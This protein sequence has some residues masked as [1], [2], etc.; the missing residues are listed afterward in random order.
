MTF[1]KGILLLNP[2]YRPNFNLKEKM[3]KGILHST[4]NI[5]SSLLQIRNKTPRF[6]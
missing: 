1:L 4:E 6:L 2:K 5:N 3:F